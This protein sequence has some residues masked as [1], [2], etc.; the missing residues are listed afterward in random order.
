MNKF[1]TSDHHLTE[2]GFSYYLERPDDKSAEE[3]VKHIESCEDCKKEYELWNGF[4]MDNRLFEREEKKFGGLKYL[5]VAAILFF[6][7][8]YSLSD[9]ADYTTNKILEPMVG[10]IFRVSDFKLIKPSVFSEIRQFPLE[11]SWVLKQDQT[12]DFYILS[13]KNQELIHYKL[14]KKQSVI[15]ED[16]EKGLYY[17][18]LELNSDLL[19][20]GK[21]IVK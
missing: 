12:V 1:F 3:I 4:L 17:W 9:K 6:G 20:L 10:Q 13:N 11:F 14:D 8:Y 2:L 7:L 5:A 16:L 21:F 19:F 15:I 18:K